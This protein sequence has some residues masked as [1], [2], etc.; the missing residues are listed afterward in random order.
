MKLIKRNIRIIVLAILVLFA[1]LVGYG[2]YSLGNFGNRWF[3]SSVNVY[4]RRQKSDVIP[5]RIYDRNGVLLASSDEAGK[6][7]Y[8][9]DAAVRSAVVHVMGDSANNVAYGVESFMAQYL[10]GFSDSYADRLR[11]A[12]SGVKRRGNDLRISIDAGLSRT[13]ARAFPNGKAGAVVVMNYR[14]GELLSLMSFPLFDP[15]NIPRN[16]EADPQ[17][18]FWNKATRWLSAPGSAFKVVTLAAALK[19]IPDAMTR[20]YECTGAY[21]VGD[22]V[23]T[24]A[25]MASHGTIN[26]EKAME[27]SCNITFAKVA[28]EVG[29]EGMR[30]AGQAFG[31]DDYFLFTDLV[32]E[33]SA[34]PTTN[35]VNKEIAWTG[36]GQSALLLTPLHMTMITAAVANDGVMMEPKIMLH[37]VSDAGDTKA[38][39]APRAY[40][41]PLESF[42]A[43]VITDAMR[44]AV[45][46]GTAT[47]A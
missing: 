16:I 8:N 46:N 30:Q 39:L 22:T 26:L 28:L 45:T 34:Y 7:Y 47:R 3:S 41:Y 21:Q 36:P 1:S 10:Y 2:A 11:Q 6:R 32:V 35:R 12:F 37:A 29:D 43:D 9:A 23:I 24:D 38:S 15:V 33:N 31:M 14:T 5:G 4:A 25:G 42:E 40:R 17:K 27:V 44:A 20:T 18:P 19:N 13:I